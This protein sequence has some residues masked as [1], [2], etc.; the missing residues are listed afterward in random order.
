[1]AVNTW[2]ATV[3]G[4]TFNATPK[5]MF[6]IYNNGAK[7]LK[8]RRIMFMNYSSGSVTGVLAAGNVNIYANMST[9]GGTSVTP[10]PKDTNN[11]ALDSVTVLHSIT[12]LSGGTSVTIRRWLWSTDELAMTATSL[13]EILNLGCGL[14]IWDEGYHVAALQP[15]TLNNKETLIIQ[16]TAYSAAAAGVV[17][18]YVEF[19]SE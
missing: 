15:L 7:K 10:I 6:S 14:T 12:S 13:D 1:M 16:A 3:S 11:T 17:D 2:Y 18:I 9:T 5:Y 4:V 19:T 8:I